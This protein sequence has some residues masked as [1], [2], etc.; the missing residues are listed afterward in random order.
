LGTDLLKSEFVPFVCS[1]LST[2]SRVPRSPSNFKGERGAEGWIEG[3]VVRKRGK[4]KKHK[5]VEKPGK[6]KNQPV[7]HRK[8]LTG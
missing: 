5:K 7:K 6:L 3:N 2:E 4:V 8:C 1:T